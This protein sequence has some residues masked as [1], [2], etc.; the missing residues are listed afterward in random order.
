MKTF[1][2]RRQTYFTTSGFLSLDQKGR[3]CYGRTLG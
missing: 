1:G 3:K 2:P